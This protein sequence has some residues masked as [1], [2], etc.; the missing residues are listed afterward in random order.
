MK[1]A[2]VLEESRT[3]DEVTSGKMKDLLLLMQASNLNGCDRNTD[4]TAGEYTGPNDDLSPGGAGSP[5]GFNRS[6]THAFG[7]PMGASREGRIIPTGLIGPGAHGR[8]RD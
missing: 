7:G 8:G 1:V 2:H 5:H 4:A 3:F 6:N